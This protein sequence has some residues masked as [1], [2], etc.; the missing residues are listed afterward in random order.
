MQL[1]QM[2]NNMRQINRTGVL[3]SH[4]KKDRLAG[5]V[6]NLGLRRVSVC[7]SVC[8]CVSACVSILC[9]LCVCNMCLCICVCVSLCVSVCVCAVYICVSVSCVSVCLCLGFEE[10]QTLTWRQAWDSP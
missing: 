2:Q 3:K 4:G 10:G 7:V 1:P 9:V 5:D 8:L 6:F